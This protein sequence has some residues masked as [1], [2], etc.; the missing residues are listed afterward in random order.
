MKPFIQIKPAFYLFVSVSL[1]VLPIQWILAW[2][3]AVLVHE[4][5]HLFAIKIYDGDV[6]GI[7][8]GAGGAEIEADIFS[9]KEEFLCAIAG[10]LGSFLL[11]LFAK[12]IPR[13]AICGMVQ[14][15]YNL[16]PVFPLDGGRAMRYLANRFFPGSKS[17]SAVIENGT[18]LSLL[19]LG[20]YCSIRLSFG[21]VP[22][23]VPVILFFKQGKVKISCKQPRQRVQ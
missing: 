17:V 11:I 18:V 9:I 6:H 15:L 3:V 12:W 22:V 1:L 23:L 20:I 16:L 19:A 2:V 13:V 4:L 14:G 5:F 7:L 21:I 10:P 8:I